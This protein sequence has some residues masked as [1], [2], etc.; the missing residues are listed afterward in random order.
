MYISKIKVAWKAFTGFINPWGS[1]AANVFEYMAD[2]SIDYL[3]STLRSVSEPTREKIQ[4]IL[5]VAQKV[6]A[7]LKA[8]ACLCPTKWQTAF[9]DTVAAVLVVTQMLDDLEI[10]DAEFT[11]M[12]D[13]FN[14]AVIAW[15]SSD[16]ETCV[17]P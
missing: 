5:N 13:S 1:A 15:K 16:D 10:T 4:R 6:L 11:Q 17:A 9:V 12:R 3:N 14:A 2:S 8:I 7:I